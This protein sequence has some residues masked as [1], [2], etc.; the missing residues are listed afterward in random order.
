MNMALNHC[1]FDI[2]SCMVHNL[3]A[4]DELQRTVHF[5]QKHTTTTKNV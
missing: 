2:T 5:I 4:S 3:Q 1:M